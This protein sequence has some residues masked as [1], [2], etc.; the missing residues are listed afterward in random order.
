MQIAH[1]YPCQSKTT[2][3]R[4]ELSYVDARNGSGVP[5]MPLLLLSLLLV[6]AVRLRKELPIQTLACRL[7]QY[8]GPGV[9]PKQRT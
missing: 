9:G 4:V 6:A 7:P 8:R 2:G 3:S 1:I 5:I